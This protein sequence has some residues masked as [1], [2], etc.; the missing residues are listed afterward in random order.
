MEI[1]ERIKAIRKQKNMTLAEMVEKTEFSLGFLSNVER[2]QTS[3]TIANLHKIC[4]VLNITLND[5]L[6]LGDPTVEDYVTVVRHDERKI[7]FEQDNG[8]LKYEAMSEGDTQ[9]KATVMTLSGDQIFPFTPHDHDEM[10]VIAEG[11]MEMQIDDKS[12]Y[13]YPGDS[14]YIKTGTMHSGKKTSKEN[15]VSY[16][17]KLSNQVK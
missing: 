16:W 1:G 12:Y 8:S 4:N 14:I 11:S 17:F 15:C 7:L 2:N 6:D 5:I 10:G 9:I 3:P 13:L